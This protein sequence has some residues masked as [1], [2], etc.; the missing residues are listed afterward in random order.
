MEKTFHVTKTTEICNT[1]LVCS[2]NRILTRE[3]GQEPYSKVH[4]KCSVQMKLYQWTMRVNNLHNEHNN[5]SWSCRLKQCLLDES[6][7]ESL[8]GVFKYIN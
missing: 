1:L 5:V 4:I 3:C 8:T 2:C 6:N 7:Q